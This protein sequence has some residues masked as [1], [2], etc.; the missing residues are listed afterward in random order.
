MKPRER[1]RAI[2]SPP[3]AAMELADEPA[4]PPLGRELVE[5]KV[6]ERGRERVGRGAR[7]A[8]AGRKGAREAAASCTRT[9]G[10]AV[11][12]RAS[13]AKGCG[14]RRSGLSVLRDVRGRQRFLPSFVAQEHAGKVRTRPHYTRLT[15]TVKSTSNGL[16]LFARTLL[17]AATY[18]CASRVASSRSASAASCLARMV[19]VTTARRGGSPAPDCE[20]RG[21]E[22]EGAAGDEVPCCQTWRESTP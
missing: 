21:E 6:G 17:A 15:A 20:A 19:S 13:E 14:R 2:D 16:P 7:V 10:Q 8:V 12:R 3:N 11:R 22:T 9:C 1:I 5:A 4:W 18:S